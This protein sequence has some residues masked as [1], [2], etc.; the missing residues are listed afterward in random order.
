MAVELDWHRDKR[1]F[2]AMTA[3]WADIPW[4]RQVLSFVPGVLTAFSVGCCTCSGA[5]CGSRITHE[6][7]ACAGREDGDYVYFVERAGVIH[8]EHVCFPGGAV[9]PGLLFNCEAYTVSPQFDEVV[10]NSIVD[11]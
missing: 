3:A 1:Y 6:I 8:E 2:N 11:N 9:P 5:G 10:F 7:A 4:V